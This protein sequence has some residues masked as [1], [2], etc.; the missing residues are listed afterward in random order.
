[1]AGLITL[2]FQMA[3]F[4]GSTS[5]ITVGGGTIVLQA[6]A[7]QSLAMLGTFPFA[8]LS[9]TSGAISIEGQPGATVNGNISF[10]VNATSNAPTVTVTNFGGTASMSWP[11]NA[12]GGFRV[13]SPGDPVTLDGFSN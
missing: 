6:Q 2:S 11:S 12:G 4:T 13:V 10:A 9:V 5:S 8:N 1:M 3:K 7:N